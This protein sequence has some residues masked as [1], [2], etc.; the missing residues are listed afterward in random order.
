VSARTFLTDL[1]FA[2]VR[3]APAGAGLLDIMETENSE[4]STEERAER[5][6]TIDRR[7]KGF[8]DSVKP[9]LIHRK[10]L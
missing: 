2:A 5:E 6:T 9:V 7:A 1:A 10:L 8:D 4:G 3:L